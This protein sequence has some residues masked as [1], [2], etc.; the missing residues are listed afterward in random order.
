M[1][2]KTKNQNGVHK[3]TTSQ[4]HSQDTPQ[5]K[6]GKNCCSPFHIV[7]FVNGSSDYIKV[8]KV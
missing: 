4:P 1:Y 6:L 7:Y 5:F 2:I 8:A 3:S